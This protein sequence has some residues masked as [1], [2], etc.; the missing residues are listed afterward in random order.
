[1]TVM[2]LIIALMAMLSACG[3]QTPPVDES[4]ACY[5]PTDGGLYNSK[6]ECDKH[7]GTWG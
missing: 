4:G 3:Q 6:A 1:M 7:N 2:A 5:H